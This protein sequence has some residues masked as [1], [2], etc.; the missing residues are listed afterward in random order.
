MGHSKVRVGKGSHNP[1]ANPHIEQ[2]KCPKSST[3]SHWWMIPTLGAS[4]VGRCKFCGDKRQFKNGSNYDWVDYQK[5]QEWALVL[6][7]AQKD[8]D[9]RYED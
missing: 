4:P 2:A 9:S 5:A 8:R 7:N 3:G 1:Q 6:I